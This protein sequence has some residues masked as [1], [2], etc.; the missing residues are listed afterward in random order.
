MK[1]LPTLSALALLVGIAVGV[2][3][4]GQDRNTFVVT[5][6]NTPTNNL[7]VYDASNRLIQTVATGGE[8]GVSGNSGGIAASHDRLAVVNQG[9]LERPPG[10]CQAHPTPRPTVPWIPCCGA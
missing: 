5:A 10:R 8:G 4:H 7:L 3:V 1:I 9:L 2:P 6:S